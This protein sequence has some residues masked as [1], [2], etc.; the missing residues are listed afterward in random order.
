MDAP[1]PA[2]SQ[3][4]PLVILEPYSGSQTA[5]E[6][7][8]WEASQGEAAFWAVVGQRDNVEEGEGFF[9][10]TEADEQDEELS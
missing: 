7:M 4:S 8:D 6:G 1:S 9:D 5:T 3:S 2:T 10:K